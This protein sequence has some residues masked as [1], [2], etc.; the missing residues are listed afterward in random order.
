MKSTLRW[1]IWFAALF[2]AYELVEDSPVAD[3][4]AAGGIVAAMCA[5]LMLRHYAVSRTRYLITWGEFGS[6]AS[7][8]AT[9]VR[10]TIAVAAA[11]VRS[12]VDPSALSGKVSSQPFDYGQT[13]DPHDAGRRA[14]TTLRVSLSPGSVVC[15]V[16]PDELIVHR[17]PAPQ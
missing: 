17:M 15:M 7:V 12:F 4:L 9:V 14:M 5:V 2:A 16:R 3:E 13:F 11:I 1:A 10:E 6:L 8:P